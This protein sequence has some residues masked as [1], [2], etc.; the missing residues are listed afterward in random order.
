[1]CTICTLKVPEV[2]E[3]WSGILVWFLNGVLRFG[4]LKIYFYV[5]M[6]NTRS[7]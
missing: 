3:S 4:L 2:I 5:C 6:Y 7:A 1:M